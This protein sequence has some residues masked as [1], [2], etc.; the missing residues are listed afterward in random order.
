MC[1]E[2]GFRGERGPGVW[3]VRSSRGEVQVFAGSG[4]SFRGER[5]VGQIGRRSGEVE[6]G[7][8]QEDIAQDADAFVIPPPAE[9]G[10]HFLEENAIKENTGSFFRNKLQAVLPQGGKDIFRQLCQL[11]LVGQ[12]GKPC[13][14]HKYVRVVTIN[15]IFQEEVVLVLKGVYSIKISLSRN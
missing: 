7:V 15:K 5:Q 3:R 1:G 9:K 13:R 10:D 12:T 6:C 4:S 8:D 14:S 2:S 11:F